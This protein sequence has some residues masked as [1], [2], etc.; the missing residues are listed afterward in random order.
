[1]ENMFNKEIKNFDDLK[2]RN[3]EI[4]LKDIDQIELKTERAKQATNSK[5]INNFDLY[6]TL[7]K[8]YLPTH[9]SIYKNKLDWENIDRIEKV[10]LIIRESGIYFWNELYIYL[11]EKYND[12]SLIIKKDG[13][14]LK[15]KDIFS[16]M[17]DIFKYNENP[18]VNHYIF[19]K[20]A[21]FYVNIKHSS[22]GPKKLRKKLYNF[23][24]QKGRFTYKEKKEELLKGVIYIYN[25]KEYC[26]LE[27]GLSKSYNTDSVFYGKLSLLVAYQ[28]MEKYKKENLN[29][30]S[31]EF[32]NILNY[33]NENIS[34]IKENYSVEGYS[35]KEIYSF[36][37]EEYNKN[38]KKKQEPKLEQKIP[39]NYTYN[40]NYPNKNVKK[41]QEENFVDLQEEQPKEFIEAIRSGRI[42]AKK[43]T[44][45]LEEFLNRKLDLI[46]QLDCKKV[47]I[48]RNAFEGYV[49][50]VLENDF[51]LLDKFFENNKT[52]NIAYGEAMF[53]IR[54]E[55]FDQLT[56]MS[57]SEAKTMLDQ[58]LMPGYRIVHKSNYEEKVKKYIK[59]IK[60]EST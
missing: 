18:K 27:N 59:K 20:M 22:D 52:G 6:K 25:N 4:L 48:G 35:I 32:R 46:D 47:K 45:E 23:F 12:L 39:A 44:K 19:D 51:I 55:N 9:P 56:I 14:Y 17:I 16:I 38:K 57:K 7:A 42:K 11:N 26:D 60:K 50:F 1:M 24:N 40:Y 8:K 29:A 28:L 31:I 2:Y 34:S 49:G 41:K 13:I 3:L 53:I 15:N 58:K 54:K 10:D 21:S 33:L 30:Q 5:N 43:N 36:A 37:K